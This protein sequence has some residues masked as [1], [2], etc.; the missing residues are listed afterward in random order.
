M[1]KRSKKGVAAAAA[2]AAAQ[3]EEEEMEAMDVD[4]QG[5]ESNRPSK[6]S[7]SS[8]LSSYA[9]KGV[10]E[11]EKEGDEGQG[12]K[13]E[14]KMSHGNSRSSK[15]SKSPRARKSPSPLHK[16]DSE[17]M[18]S[19]AASPRAQQ[20]SVALAVAGTS[21]SPKAVL[22][23]SSPKNGSSSKSRRP[24]RSPSPS[25]PPPPPPFRPS[26]PAPTPAP[27]SSK[28]VSSAAPL[29]SAASGESGPVHK[30]TA[31]SL[32]NFAKRL[33]VPRAPQEVEVP[34]AIPLND[35]I[36]EGFGQE[37]VHRPTA[38]LEE[39]ESSEEEEGGEEGGVGS[40]GKPGAVGGVGDDKDENGEERKGDA[41]VHT[42]KTLRAW[43]LWFS[44][45]EETLRRAFGRFGELERFEMLYERDTKKFRGVVIATY[46]KASDAGRA[47]KEM[48]GTRIDNRNV[49]LE[50]SERKKRGSM[51][52]GE[53]R[54]FLLDKTLFC[55]RCHEVG[56][57]MKFCPNPAKAKPCT[58]CAAI[59]GG[60]DADSCPEVVRAGPV[61]VLCLQ[62]G[63]SDHEDSVCIRRLR[64]TAELK[65]NTSVRCLRCAQMGHGALCGPHAAAAA[66][67]AA[68]D[69]GRGGGRKAPRYVYCFRCGSS[70]HFGYHCDSR[71][72]GGTD[73]PMLRRH[74]YSGTHIRYNATDPP[75]PPLPQSGPP[76]YE[77]P[78]H[79]P[80]HPLVPAPMAPAYYPQQGRG[81]GVVGG[82]S[83]VGGGGD[84]GGGSRHDR[85]PAPPP[86]YHA[87][88]ASSRNYSPLREE[89][90][91]RRSGGNERY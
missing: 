24:S 33:L 7:K 36:L 46:K 62:C 52:K 85:N 29:P 55:R 11:E 86:Q 64:T 27:A 65:A 1:S 15:N 74:S 18:L 81:G 78:S 79:I 21:A 37:H 25:L 68:A 87:A 2:A 77:A 60:H 90:Q 66:A 13:D 56:H 72:Q 61:G 14:V 23:Y 16:S 40:V 89:Y 91:G 47:L 39:E 4:E 10:D 22:P 88:H 67:T 41:P 26:V 51:G 8:P 38:Q 43:N 12:G 69:S 83:S 9:L 44:S 17:E 82:R 54:Y 80:Q 34:E 6:K 57:T 63:A 28:P 35:F 76:A 84:G 30:K 70:G 50:A 59:D 20:D 73:T 19:R 75:P 5:E 32:S 48:E 42:C 71:P 3:A 58:I 45:T 31:A 53:S 49:F